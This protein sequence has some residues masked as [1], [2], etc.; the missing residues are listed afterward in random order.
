ML[1]VWKLSP[2]VQDVISPL[3]S[4]Y[5]AYPTTHVSLVADKFLSV[6]QNVSTVTYTVAAFSVSAKSM[7]FVI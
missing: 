5:C 6:F 1:R 3:L 7:A 2:F 4:F